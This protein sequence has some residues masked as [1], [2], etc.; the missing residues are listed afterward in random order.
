MANA[1]FTRD[2]VILALDVLYYSDGQSLSKNS[3][4]IAELCELLQEL[5]IHPRE[6]RPENFRNA[7][8]VSEQL[9]KF[10]NEQLGV[11][12]N[13]WK[14]GTTF[15]AISKEYSGHIEDL[16]L[17][18]QA[19]RRNH[20][21]FKTCSF[22]NITEMDGFPEGALLSHLH[23]HI[24][25]RDTARL[26]RA[27]RCAICKIAPTEIYRTNDLLEL[28]L[29]VPITELDASAKYRPSDYV[30]VCP[31]CHAALHRIRPWLTGETMEEILH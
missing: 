31:N 7:M 27:D 20:A 12:H 18:A 3:P 24:E 1:S 14:V 9:Y 5:P 26:Q 29:L 30:T 16:H 22:G 13:T 10:S 25:A 4:A 8:G 23:R 21:Y 11:N 6:G 17:I 15:H 2:E 28:H 19:I